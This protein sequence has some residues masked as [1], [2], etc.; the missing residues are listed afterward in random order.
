MREKFGIL[1][2]FALLGVATDLTASRFPF[3]F[4]NNVISAFDL[5]SAIC[6]DREVS[7]V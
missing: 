1:I 2:Q 7:L 3:D 6:N 4:R 5:V